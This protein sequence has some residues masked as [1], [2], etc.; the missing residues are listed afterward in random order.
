MLELQTNFNTKGKL[1]QGYIP[2]TNILP[3]INKLK[4]KPFGKS[5]YATLHIKRPIYS[6][7]AMIALVFEVVC[8]KKK[9]AQ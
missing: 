4:K 3:I 2:I 8:G 1:M 9:R 7:T 5:I 6:S